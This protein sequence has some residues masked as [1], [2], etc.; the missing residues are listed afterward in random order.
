MSIRV[1]ICGIT[2]IQDAE[3]AVDAGADALG[4][5]LW[6][7]S[8]R[9]VLVAD[10]MRMSHKLPPYVSRVGVFVN[11]ARPILLSALRNGRL[12]VAQL[13][14]GEEPEF[15]DGLDADWYRAF[16]VDGKDDPVKIVREIA[17]FGARAYMLDTRTA[18]MPGGTGRT[19]DWGFA[20]EIG[21]RLLEESARGAGAAGGAAGKAG[22]TG[23]PRMILAGGLTSGNVGIAVRALTSS[24]LWA[25]D[26]SSGVE[27]SPGIKDHG[28]LKAFIEAARSAA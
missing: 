16:K 26:V 15:G 5:V 23:T 4:F 11:E 18:G 6:N 20:A 14:G 10:V 3:A 8:P 1:K 19:F 21:R 2:R 24:G 13:H 9:R 12:G 27:T 25:V 17:R 22:W 28:L 7:G